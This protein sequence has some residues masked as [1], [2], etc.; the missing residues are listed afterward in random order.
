MTLTGIPKTASGGLNAAKVTITNSTASKASYAVK[1]EFVDASGTTVDTT[2]VGAENLEP[3]RQAS[4]I[5]FS[6]K[7][8]DATLT[9]RAVQAQRY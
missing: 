6:T 8:T 4:P 1:V 3:G 9:P 5:A 7:D 2:V